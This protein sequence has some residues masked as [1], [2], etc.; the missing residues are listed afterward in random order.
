MIDSIFIILLGFFLAVI[1]T[2]LF[3]FFPLNLLKVDFLLILTIYVGFYRTPFKGISLSFL[4]GNMLDVFSGNPAGLYAFL[5]VLSCSLSKALSSKIFLEGVL[6]QI[7][8]V[9]ALS[10]VDSLA[11]VMIML[12][13]QLGSPK[14]SMVFQGIFRQAFILALVSPLLLRLLRRLEKYPRKWS[15]KNV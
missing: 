2:S 4:L 14:S 12:A 15:L 9:F 8:V 11:M 1:Q 5:R 3:S 6:L 10:I 7:G 13:F